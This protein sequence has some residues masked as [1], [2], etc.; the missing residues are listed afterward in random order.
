M[1][2]DSQQRYQLM[3]FSILQQQEQRFAE[4]PSAVGAYAFA[5]KNDI[6]PALHDGVTWH[7]PFCD[8]FEIPEKETMAV[9]DFLSD[10]W[11]AKTPVS[12]YDLENHFGVSGASR[13]NGTFTRW[14]LC[15]IVRYLA[16]DG[17]RFDTE[18][19]DAL[20]K[21]GDAPS[22]ALSLARPLRADEISPLD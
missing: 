1:S 2:E 13:S 20:L 15:R 18:F 21:N 17:V 19:W 11:E 5:W 7:V 12:F 14:K 3:K 6:Y 16:L 8:S 4:D 10:Q 9:L 22:E